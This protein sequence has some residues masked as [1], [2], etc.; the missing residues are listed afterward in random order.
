MTAAPHPSRHAQ[1]PAPQGDTDV[2]RSIAA[3]PGL[4]DALRGAG[5]RR[6]LDE[7]LDLPTTDPRQLA[8]NLRDLRLLNR[9]LGWSTAVSRELEAFLQRRGLRSATVL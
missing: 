6:E 7:L 8:G 1:K 9:V 2:S 3:P 5:V 4:W